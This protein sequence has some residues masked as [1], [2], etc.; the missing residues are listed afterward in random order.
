MN[1][2]INNENNNKR[3]I[4]IILVLVVIILGMGIYITIDKG[5]I[6]INLSQ[7]EKK[8]KDNNKISKNK[9]NEKEKNIE[10][11]EEI[12]PLDLSK[13]LN[14]N[15]NTI[16]SN[17]SESLG[18]HGLA[19]EITQDKTTAI[20]SIDWN[21]FGPLST[22][23]AWSSS[24][25][26]YPITGFTKN[27]TSAFVGGYGQDSMGTTL[28]Y[29]MDDRTVEYTPMFNQ[30]PDNQ[31]NS[32]YEMNYSLDNSTT[33]QHF[34]T[35]GQITGVKNIVKLYIANASTSNGS[36]WVTTIAATKDGSFYDL[37]NLISNN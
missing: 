4:T 22:A 33:G 28:F 3:L 31:G 27:I 5:V 7:K 11:Q 23:T 1:E 24:V 26:K 37:G 20:L 15:N 36:G 2:N 30:K 34:A 6:S 12:K 16:Y 13:C 25:E 14:N 8:N 9:E 35:K 18:D 19:V 17:P 29:L 10:E 32:Y 21:K